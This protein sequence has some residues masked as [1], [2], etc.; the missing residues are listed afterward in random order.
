MHPDATTAAT[1]STAKS[2]WIWAKLRR[3]S[4]TRPRRESSTAGARACGGG[5][6][7]EPH[8]KLANTVG[9][10]RPEVHDVVLRQPIN[11]QR[12][13]RRR[14]TDPGHRGEFLGAAVAIEAHV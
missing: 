14:Q 12:L 6:R 8:R 11:S 2:R 10:P 7:V 13:A 4:I 9:G 1:S 3:R 5:A